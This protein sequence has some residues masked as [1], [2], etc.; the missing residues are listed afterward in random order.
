ME[1]WDGNVQGAVATVVSNKTVTIVDNRAGG[2]LSSTTGSIGHVAGLFAYQV[3]TIP[4]GFGVTPGTPQG[5]Q[6]EALAHA[7]G[8]A[9]LPGVNEAFYAADEADIQ[10]A[11]SQILSKSVRSEI[12]NLRDDDC[13]D[14]RIDQVG[15]RGQRKQLIGLHEPGKDRCVQ[16]ILD[17]FQ[18]QPDGHITEVTEVTSSESGNVGSVPGALED[19]HAPK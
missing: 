14:P 8:A 12:C 15:I 1:R 7:G 10:L 19:E 17:R 11:I 3:Q 18:D 4:I 13:D 2:D 6:M 9:D 5:L 16:K